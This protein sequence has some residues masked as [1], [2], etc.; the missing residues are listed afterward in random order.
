MRGL[1]VSTFKKEGRS[2]RVGRFFFLILFYEN[3]GISAPSNQR[4]QWL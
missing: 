4:A 3:V 2:K 1:F